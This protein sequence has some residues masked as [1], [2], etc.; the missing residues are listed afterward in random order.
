MTGVFSLLGFAAHLYA[1]EKDLALAEQAILAEL[2]VLVRDNAREAIGTYKYGW[3]QLAES[4]QKDRA[5][6]GYPEN[7][8]L[9]RTGEL[10][11]SIMIHLERHRAL[12]GSNSDIAVYQ[13]LGTSR[14]PPRSFLLSS[15][16]QATKE[17]APIAKKYLRAAFRGDGMH[18]S[19]V[20]EMMR[21]IHLV[22]EIAKE[23]YR[24]G[25]RMAK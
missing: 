11:N 16:M 5:T 8:P 18:A 12:V 14:I 3:P 25:K 22:V 13:E 9:L 6:K 10:R 21:A 20:H 4:T 23:V 7:E 2:A 24:T 17:I 19:G 15:A 1:V